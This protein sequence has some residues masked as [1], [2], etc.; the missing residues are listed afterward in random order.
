MGSRNTLKGFA[1]Q[2]R[3]RMNSDE[4]HD[5][6]V[7]GKVGHLFAH[8]AGWFGIVLEAP[9]NST[10]LDN[11]L[12]SR[13]R[14]AIAAGLLLRQEG[15]F[16]AILLFEPTDAKQARLAIRLIQAKK[17]KK[18]P[19][20]TDAQLRVRALFSSKARSKR[21]CFDQNADAAVGQGGNPATNHLDWRMSRRLPGRKKRRRR[22]RHLRTLRG[23]A[24][25]RQRRR[26]EPLNRL[27]SRFQD[28]AMGMASWR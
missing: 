16:E 4:C 7:R 10:F 17:I 23:L 14:R 18:A 12:R 6:M 26:T 2:H 22:T 11:T 15:D 8:D 27:R 20:P 24:M 13:K 1:E 5:A 25:M 21:P 3:L 9:A 28:L 19:P